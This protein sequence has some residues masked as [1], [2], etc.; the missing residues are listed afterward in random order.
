MARL[1]AIWLLAGVA[2]GVPAV[3][4]QITS[5]LS[6]E[7]R[8]RL[9]IP[10]GPLPELVT[11]GTSP[12][13]GYTPEQAAQN[14]PDILSV[15]CAHLGG[16]RLLFAITFASR[17]DF[18]GATFIIYVDAD[19]NPAT[20]RQ[21]EHHG[22]VDFM[23][24][25][26]GNQ[27]TLSSHNPAHTSANTIVRA[28]RVGPVLYV[29]VDTAL[30][31]TD[32]LAVGIHLLSQCEGGQSDSTRHQVV[33]LP[34]SSAAVPDL[35]RGSSSSLRT[36]ED[37]RYVDDL[38]QY[39]KLADKGLR[40]DQ[41]APREPFRP[42]RPC[43]EPL[44]T[45]TPKHPEQ[46]GS[47]TRTR[48]PVSL[49]EETGT[50]RAQSP[51]SF[52]FPCPRGGIFDPAHMRVL[53]GDR[54]IPA[55][56][57]ITAFWPDGSLKWVLVDFLIDLQAN[58]D[59]TVTVELGREVQRQPLDSP[60]RI[61]DQSDQLSVITG[62]HRY[63]LGKRD[64]RV[65]N[66]ADRLA[67]D[68]SRPL[69]VSELGMTLTNE[70]QEVFCT[71]Y[72]APERVV[73]EQ[74]G[75][76]K[77]VVR[78]EG[79]Y[80]SREP[81]TYMKYVGRMTFWA[82]S[83][84]V[85]I[86]WTT[87]NDYLQTEF[88]DVSTLGLALLL[89]GAPRANT[90][91]LFDA[92]GRLT[93]QPVAQA[94]VTQ[95]TDQ[96]G[97]LEEFGAEDQRRVELDRTPGVVR[98][99]S[100][101][102]SITLAVQDFWQRW[103]KRLEVGPQ[104]LTFM[105]LPPQPAPDFGVGLP[106]YL[107]YNLCEGKYRFKWGMSF[108]DRFAL[109]FGDQ[110][111]AAALYA[112]VNQ[113]V[114]AV[115][116]AAWYAETG[117]LGRLAP[118]LEKQFAVWDKWVA[119]AFQAN[120]RVK[121]RDRE[122]GFLNYG[123]WYGERGRNWGNNEYDYAHG[124]F[125]DFL[126]TGNRD[127]YRWALTAARHQAE[128]DVVHAY[129]DGFYVGGQVPHSVG[130]TGAWSE[131]LERGTWQCR[132]DSMVTAANGHNWADGM[133]DAWCLSGDA[134]VMQSAL[135]YG[136]H[137]AWA[138]SPTFKAL[139]THERSAGWSLKGIMALYNQTYDPEYLAA[140][141]RIAEVALR[142]QDLAGCG[143]WPHVLPLD[144]ANGQANVV[145]NNLFLIGVL[146]GG[147]QAY[148]EAVQD[149]AVDQALIAGVRWVAKSWDEA[150][151]GW[152]YSATPE[153]RPLY[154]AT[155]SLN[156]L[157]IQPVA[158]VAKL[159][160]DEALWHIV[161]EAL[162]AV[163]VGGADSFGK[164]VAQ[165]LH[166]AGGTLALLQEHYAQAR[167]DRGASVLSG[168]AAWLAARM[169]KTPAAKRHSVRAP[170]DKVFWI[171]LQAAEAELTCSRSPHGAMTKRSPTGTLQ[172]TSSGG[173][174]IGEDTF[175]TDGAHEY[176]LKLAGQ[177]GDQFRVHINDDQRG[178]WTLAGANLKIVMQTDPGFRI[179]GV[180]RGRY[181]FMVPAG[182]PEFTLKLLGVHTGGY[183]AVVLTPR[184]QIAGQHEDSNP[185]AALIPGAA[186]GPPVPDTHPERG[187]ITVRPEPQDTGKLW[188][189]V[190]WA[191]GDIGV[192][193]VGLPPYLSLSEEAWF[194]PVTP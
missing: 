190:L 57:T 104:G 164:S 76:I 68:G 168:D 115:I 30:P 182:T 154:P 39:E 90:V 163:A 14:A 125:Q 107:L 113:P 102:G 27:V 127:H 45:T 18:V 135:L 66:S 49:L 59:K 142:E 31:D 60:L 99:S 54:E 84:R 79:H 53:E 151:G 140:A 120:M 67:A 71:A 56:F 119:D 165:K 156:M 171:E 153:G 77:T 118:P 132:Y 81:A 129:P 160:G 50:D 106:H 93:A 173:Q 74:A 92:D 108:T 94:T 111:S 44:F 83:P 169:A 1:V 19:N 95:Y 63:S 69:V 130:H 141:R 176:R 29:T 138:M 73:V 86:A 34:R 155:T 62:P 136:E 126:R 16:Q 89:R 161:E 17:P 4:Q 21:D 166:F 43:P 55:Q 33:Q 82:G 143:A 72:S 148:A 123:D 145:G 2:L 152:P 8:A 122:Y 87:I 35:P 158:Y 58:E 186:P 172:V 128:V 47:L 98:C 150:V 3:A 192:E 100:E 147:L 178:V 48:V 65:L 15:G 112:D 38:V 188:S 105:P 11:A 167:P 91:Y 114:V 101:N 22:G 6:P 110:T 174:V 187:Q 28:A 13:A 185:G 24:V 159:T 64:F 179:G 75:P 52:G 51:I 157:I 177:P 9:G 175:S 162:A 116:P 37:F 96:Q 20:G 32:P 103:P 170:D 137:V 183:G 25:A 41:V 42:G 80:G 70:A 146:L 10:E 85:G 191:A 184:G 46:V 180:G 88:T 121:E 131:Q 97:V 181:W 78:V 12:D 133:V 194:Q 26:I 134:G 109:D 23:L 5:D 149:P 144:H 36:A 61:E 117:A 189:V 40:F 139:G 124:L 193:L 7:L